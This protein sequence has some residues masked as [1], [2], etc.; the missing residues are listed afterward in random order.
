MTQINVGRSANGSYKA[1]IEGQP[2]WCY[3]WGNTFADA[4]AN[5]LITF[6]AT[7]GLGI[8]INNAGMLVEPLDGLHHSNACEAQVEAS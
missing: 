1:W 3:G 5:F 2:S 7:N 8:H 4:L 6:Q